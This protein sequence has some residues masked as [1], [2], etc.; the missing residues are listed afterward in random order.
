MLIDFPNGDGQYM[1]EEIIITK[2]PGSCEMLDD[3][4]RG[5]VRQQVRSQTYQSA[6]IKTFENNMNDH[7]AIGVIFGKSIS[8][9]SD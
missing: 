6:H 7:V 4:S 9:I 3:D 1:D 8:Y 5:R 2:A